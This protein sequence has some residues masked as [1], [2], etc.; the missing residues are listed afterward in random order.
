MQFQFGPYSKGTVN[1]SYAAL[2]G[3]SIGCLAGRAG[4]EIDKLV[5]SSTGVE[6]NGTYLSAFTLPLPNP[7]PLSRERERNNPR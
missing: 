7:P 4:D 3:D 2:A 6:I 5:I 1:G